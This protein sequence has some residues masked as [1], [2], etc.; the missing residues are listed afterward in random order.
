MPTS[1][2]KNKLPFDVRKIYCQSVDI[3]QQIINYEMK[4]ISQEEFVEKVRIIKNKYK[5]IKETSG[6]LS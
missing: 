2:D 1:K 4:V 3:H 5:S 6:I